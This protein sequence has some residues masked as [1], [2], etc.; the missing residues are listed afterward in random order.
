MTRTE[1]VEEAIRGGALLDL[2][3]LVPNAARARHM[4]PR[5]YE[6]AVCRTFVIDNCM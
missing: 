1:L 3:G 6:S 2:M 4:V 5:A